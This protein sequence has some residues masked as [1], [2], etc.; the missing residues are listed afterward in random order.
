M[1]KNSGNSG[2][3]PLTYISACGKQTKDMHAYIYIY[4]FPQ[5]SYV[6]AQASNG[7]GFGDGVF[8]R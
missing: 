3:I 8:G 6:E 5:N 7:M 2:F 1:V 4:T